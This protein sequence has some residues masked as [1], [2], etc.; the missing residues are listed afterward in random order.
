MKKILVAIACMAC[1]FS[2]SA[3]Q[4]KSTSIFSTEKANQGITWGI[5]GGFNLSNMKFS[6]DNESADSKAGFN[7]GV[8]IDFPLLQSLYLQTGLYYTTKG[9]KYN[10]EEEDYKTEYKCTPQY[11]EIPVMASYRYNF[12]KATQLQINF[13]PYFAYGIA[14]KE[15]DTNEY[16]GEKEEDKFDV[17]GKDGV[18]NRFDAGLGIGGGITI[19]KF[20]IGLNYQFGLA[21]I[22]KDAEGDYSVKNKNF[23]ISVGY[24]F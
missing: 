9:Y 15:K 2:V 22:A 3:Q 10:E 7:V 20:F 13:G 8:N 23:S 4:E 21:N 18:F 14:G 16:E 5:R 24:N 19:K 12:N 11:L 17:F 1:V 6:G